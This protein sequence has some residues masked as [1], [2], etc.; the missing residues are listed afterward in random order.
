MAKLVLREDF[1]KLGQ[2]LKAAKLVGSGVEAKIVILDGKVKVNGQVE[3]HRCYLLSFLRNRLQMLH[4]YNHSFLFQLQ[5]K[6]C[7]M[8]RKL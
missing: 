4:R 2:A 1:I 6:K 3:L 7:E 8:Y 5:N